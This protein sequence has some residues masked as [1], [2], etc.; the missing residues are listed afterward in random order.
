MKTTWE[1]LRQTF[2][3]WRQ[4]EAFM[5][6]AALAFYAA[7]SLAPLVT[8]SLSFASVFYGEEALRGEL[9]TQVRGYTG[10][11]G[12]EVIQNILA[13]AH[14]HGSGGPA[15]L[16]VGLLLVGAS[17][18]FAQLQRAMNRVW[19]VSP[20]PGRPWF[21]LLRVR[22]LSVAL[23]LGVGA[24]LIAFTAAGALLSGVGNFVTHLPAPGVAMLWQAVNFLLGVTVFTGLFAALFKL[25]PDAIIRWRDVWVGALATALLFN[26]GRLGIGFYLGRYAPGSAYGATGSLVVLLLWLYFS[27]LILFLGAELTQV[28]ARRLGT[29]IRPAEHAH[30][31]S[32]RALP[33]DDDGNPILEPRAGAAGCGPGK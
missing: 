30:R 21:Q 20:K 24:L 7:V 32:V 12:A 18:V 10:K 14:R 26:V 8:M 4:D 27:A 29:R 1:I 16:S 6:A 25:L 11:S 28:L 3:Q 17:A 19:N 5:L 15:G 9:V 31:V 22:L 33:V 2:R 23:V 13:S